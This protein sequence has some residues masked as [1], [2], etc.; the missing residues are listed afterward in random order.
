MG[1]R[2]QA[3]RPPATI[4]RR[5]CFVA[6]AALSVKVLL[7]ARSAALATAAWFD[8]GGAEA[9]LVNRRGGMTVRVAGNRQ[10]L[11]PLPRADRM[12]GARASFVRRRGVG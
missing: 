11:G 5:F 9:G 10:G 3:E 2:C 7:A 4:P 12:A 6:D 1:R 8:R